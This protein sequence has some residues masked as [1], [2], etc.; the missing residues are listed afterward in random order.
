MKVETEKLD[1]VEH[2]SR[3]LE[4]KDI[5]LGFLQKSTKG[6]DNR[7]FSESYYG[8]VTPNSGQS[9]GPLSMFSVFFLMI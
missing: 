2:F 9:K 5:E 7:E 3:L 6:E 4:E 1:L 8:T